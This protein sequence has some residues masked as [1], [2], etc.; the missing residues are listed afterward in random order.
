MP[1]RL[2]MGVRQKLVGIPPS[3]IVW[4][5]TAAN[6]RSSSVASYVR[7]DNFLRHDPRNRRERAVFNRVRIG[8][9]A[10][11]WFPLRAYS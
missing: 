1:I 3:G 5:S 9:S 6:V 11:A 4:L 7:S 8:S 2:Q 10:Q